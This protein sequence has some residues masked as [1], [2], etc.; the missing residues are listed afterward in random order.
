MKRSEMVELMAE[1]MEKNFEV[2]NGSWY[3]YAEK[4]LVAM[5]KVGMKPPRNGH[6]YDQYGAGDDYV[7]YSTPRYEWDK[8]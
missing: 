7:C 4:V 6:N 2:N 8:E 3:A 5:E 1:V